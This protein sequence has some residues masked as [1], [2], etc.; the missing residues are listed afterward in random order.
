MIYDCA[1]MFSFFEYCDPGAV[2]LRIKEMTV[3]FETF[4][5]TVRSFNIFKNEL[6]RIKFDLKYKRE[7]ESFSK[8]EKNFYLFFNKRFC[9]KIIVASIKRK[10]RFK[11]FKMRFFKKKLSKIEK[12]FN[13]QNNKRFFK[14]PNK[15]RSYKR[16]N[17]RFFRKLVREAKKKAT[18]KLKMKAKLLQKKHGHIK[19]KQS[20]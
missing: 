13:N 12:F 9:S 15:K 19:S 18:K 4:P 11:N 16:F 3:D 1:T 10:A 8:K 17:V 20:L 5:T 7:T 6:T 14:K 2:F